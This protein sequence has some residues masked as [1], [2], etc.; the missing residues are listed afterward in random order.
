MERRMRRVGRVM[1]VLCMF[2]AIGATSCAQADSEASRQILSGAGD[3]R[4]IIIGEMHGTREI[5]ALVGE[6]A[7]RYSQQGPLLLGIEI[8]RGEHDSLRDYLSSPIPAPSYLAARPAWQKPRTAN[9][10]RRSKAM[11]ALIEVMRRLRAQ[12]RDVAVLPFDVSR[13]GNGAEA[14]D[15]AMADYLRAAYQALPNGRLLVL[16]GN[17]HAMQE[18]PTY[19][20]QCQSPMTSY[21]RDLAPFSVSVVA[22]R[23]ASWGCTARC[24][25]VPVA[26]THLRGGPTAGGRDDVY[27]FVTVLPAFTPAELIEAPL[28]PE[29]VW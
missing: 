20:P 4:L 6:L 22:E 24:G 5:P 18:K 15:H 16:A 9:D 3:S 13:S 27:S 21:L 17:V 2:G 10:G 26:P 7:N 28:A 19:C 29:G 12:G 11:L 8:S 1:A 25:P 23:G 14:R